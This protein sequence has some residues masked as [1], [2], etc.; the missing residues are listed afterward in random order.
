MAARADTEARTP[1]PVAEGTE[2]A[3]AVD[4]LEVLVEALDRL[5]VV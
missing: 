5:V 3:A 2:A 4:E 1:A